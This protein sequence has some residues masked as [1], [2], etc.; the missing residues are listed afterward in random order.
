LSALEAAERFYSEA[1]ALWPEDDAE[2]PHLLLRYGRVLHP[3]GRGEEVLALASEELLD[4]GDREAAAEAET[5][6]GD[7]LWLHARHEEAFEHLEGAVALLADAPPSR[8][9]AFA[10]AD[11]ARFRMMGDEAE[12]AVEAG[13]EAL[14]MAEAL[15]L[16]ELRASALNTL[17]VCRVL[18]GDRGG[19]DDLE[20]AIEISR[21]LRSFQLVRAY[22]NLASTLIALGE[23]ER[24]YDLYAEA[25]AAAKQVG[26]SAAVLWVEAEQT[27]AYY[28]R[29]QWDEAAAAANGILADSDSGLPHVREVDARVIRALVRLGRGDEAGANEDSAAG[30]D[31]AHGSPDPQILF[32]ALACR[33]RVLTETGS[34]TDADPLVTDLL[35]RWRANPLTFASPWLAYVAPSIVALGRAEQLADVARH[36]PV[37]TRWL[38]AAL[39]LVDNPAEAARIYAQIG[40]LPDEAHARLRT[41]EALAAAGRRPE[42]DEELARAL[43]FYRAVG[44]ARYAREGEALL[45]AP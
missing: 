43:D 34:A 44:A 35:D 33:A 45:A 13:S 41:A 18:T 37:Q 2:R 23:L 42:A 32:P 31:L 5:L 24:A 16:D 3:H 28:L 38:E 40:S 7:V 1:L 26:W 36:A 20:R 22:N 14:K 17:G 10:L 29:G 11:L 21:G 30:L 39:A 12:K 6:L 9:K 8:A 27:D 25:L 15:E 19:L 4:A